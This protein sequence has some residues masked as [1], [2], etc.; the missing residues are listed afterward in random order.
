VGK[1][2][3]FLLHKGGREGGR[4]ESQRP[5]LLKISRGAPCA[6][7]HRQSP[8]EGGTEGRREEGEEGHLKTNR[9]YEKGRR[10]GGREGGR[11]YQ[12]V[13]AFVVE[14]VPI[15]GGRERGREGRREG[16]REDRKERGREGG[17]RTKQ[18]TPS[19]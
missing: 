7:C 14:H 3:L 4:G 10:E 9:G 13:D 16:G 19:L 6:W 12:A 17:G 1:R 5:C 2:S 18:S 15:K 11:T 8:R